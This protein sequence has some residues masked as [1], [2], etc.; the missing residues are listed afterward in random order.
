M[1]EQI[2]ELYKYLGI[3]EEQFSGKI[4]PVM[5]ELTSKGMK[6]DTALLKIGE[7]KRLND[8]ERIYCA[9]AIGR[10][11]GI[12]EIKGKVSGIAKKLGLV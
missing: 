9:Y 8:I 3:T 5:N 10:V 11:V 2:L 4:T 7:D 1:T 6:V 12:D